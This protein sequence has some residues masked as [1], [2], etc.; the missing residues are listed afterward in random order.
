MPDRFSDTKS[1]QKLRL[2]SVLVVLTGLVLSSKFLSYHGILPANI[3]L[4]LPALVV[5]GLFRVGSIGFS[6]KFAV[7]ALGVAI[8]FDFVFWGFNL[9]YLWTWGA[10]IGVWRWSRRE[11]VD[12]G[13][14]SKKDLAIK[15]GVT[16]GIGILAYDLITAFGSFLV[17]QPMSLNG[18]FM[19]YSMQFPFTV[20]HLVSAL[21]APLLALGIREI[22]TYRQPVVERVCEREKV[23]VKA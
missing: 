20:Y 5:A 14:V 2:I 7:V 15:S 21:F 17:W 1:G 13:R 19:T 6:E 8:V 3:E 22:V 11:N 18:L 9:I 12:F 23:R 4:L 16:A 10:V